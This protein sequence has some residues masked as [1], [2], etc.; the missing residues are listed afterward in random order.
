MFKSIQWKILTVFI[1]LVVSVMILVG[2]ILMRNINDY[3]LKEF[4]TQMD[5]NVFSQ[6]FAEQLSAAAKGEEPVAAMHGLLEAYNGRMGIDSFRNYYILDK[7]G[8]IAFAPNGQTG[9]IAASSNLLSA[10]SGKLGNEI[11][12]ASEIMDYAYPVTAGGELLYIIYVQDTKEEVFDILNN[13]FT[14]IL[15]ALAVGLFMS[16]ILG[17]FLSRTIIAPIASLQKKAEKIAAGDFGSKIEVKASDEIGDLTRAFNSMSA[18]LSSNI[19]QIAGEKNKIETIFLYMTDGVVAFNKF[20]EM[21]HVNT[22][23]KEMLSIEDGN[24]SFEEL[25]KPYGEDISLKSILYL[26]DNDDK[27]FT[28][29]IKTGDRILKAHFAPFMSEG[30]RVDGVV[31]VFQ[32]I[33]EQQKLDNDRREFVAN[34]S[35]ELRTPLT[36]IKSYTETLQQSAQKDSMEETFLEVINSEAD[37]MTRLVKDLLTLSRLDYDRTSLTKTNFDL[38]KLCANIVEKLGMEAKKR[39]HTLTF[40]KRGALPAFFGDKDRLEQVIINIVTNA[41]KYTPDGGSVTVSCGYY[42]TD[43]IITVTD[44]GIGIPKEDLPHIFD[45]FYRV[46]K[47]RTRKYGGTGLGLAIAKEIIEAHNGKIEIQSKPRIGT[48]VTITMPIYSE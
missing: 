24:I 17:L 25:F 18:D 21:I 9:T 38:Q 41:L 35:H 47:A 23:A 28:R 14:I 6:D 48:E 33:T 1:L 40:T 43:A 39:G 19:A 12:T 4:T 8:N 45:R 27:G 30:R 15:I 2:V 34:V 26:T 3:Y 29:E 11:N 42:F 10:M 37:R 16:I 46:D 36:T 44:T 32:D 13:I 31:I 22:A 7:I 5:R 20:G